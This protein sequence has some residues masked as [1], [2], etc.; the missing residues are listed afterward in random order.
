MIAA[1]VGLY[2]VLLWYMPQ[3][4]RRDLYFSVTVPPSFRDTPNAR[5]TL[6][7]YRLQISV[8]SVALAAITIVLGRV[9]P[10]LTQLSLY[11]ETI[12]SLAAFLHARH[13][14][15]PHAVEPTP[16]REASLNKRPRIVP[17][18]LPAV[19]GPF[20]IIAAVAAY[21]WTHADELPTRIPVHFDIHMQPDGWASRTPATLF[22]PLLVGFTILVTI[23]ISLYGLGHWV[24]TVYSGGV[25]GAREVRFRRIAALMSLGT[26]YVVTAELT[27]V[28]LLPYLTF[29]LSTGAAVAVGFA[30]L[31]FVIVAV[32]ALAR[33]GP[34]GSG[35]PA[36]VDAPPVG[37]R[38]SDRYW[39]LGI[40]YINPD[41]PA[42]MVEKRF[43]LG[44]TFNF[45][46]IVSWLVV[47][48]P[49]VVAV[50][51]PFVLHRAS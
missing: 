46:H 39:R 42:I 16:V 30:P 49:I 25:L 21:V 2:G 11:A 19:A 4:T 17:G 27:F 13:L 50:L 1:G 9:N 22:A 6:Y 3:L 38:T 47:L 40:F 44:Y 26:A 28:A 10:L 36:A 32:V 24:R 14:T 45:G 20:V 43:G 23:A 7:R 37:D 35:A 8:V 29:R 48:V 31:F 12:A 18:G 15:Q 5:R 41:D 33:L 51:V 34:W